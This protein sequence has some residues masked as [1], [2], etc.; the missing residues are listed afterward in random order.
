MNL[1]AWLFKIRL[2]FF[3]FGSPIYIHV[4]V[5]LKFDLKFNYENIN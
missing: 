2:H 3:A 1:I 4:G 5:I